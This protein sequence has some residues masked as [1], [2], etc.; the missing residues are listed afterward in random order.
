MAVRTNPAT[1]WMSSLDI[2][3]ARCF[4]TVFT[5]TTS[6]RAITLFVPPSARSWRTW[7]SRGVSRSKALDSSVSSESVKNSLRMERA[8][9]G[10]R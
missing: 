3:L 10:L 7:R 6:S 2:R 8:I 4:S 5:L 1:S 9:G